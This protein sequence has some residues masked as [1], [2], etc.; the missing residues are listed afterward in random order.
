MTIITTTPPPGPLA[1]V[2]PGRPRKNPPAYRMPVWR[3]SPPEDIATLIE[4]YAGKE[5]MKLER[6]AIELGTSAK[7]LRR[8]M[9]EDPILQECYERGRARAEHEY[10]SLIVEGARNGDKLNMNAVYALNNRHGWR[11]E[12][13]N[14]GA[15]V[16]VSITLPA[17]M[18]A[19]EYLK[20]LQHT[21]V[22]AIGE[23]R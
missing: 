18:S 6:I 17:P 22:P 8:W 7:T 11:N 16:A 20:T 4:R 9:Q 13:Q 23:V 1:Q 2:G 3:E 5:H 14:D 21:V 12:Q 10:Y 15:R 19:E